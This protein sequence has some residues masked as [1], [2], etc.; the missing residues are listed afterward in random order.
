VA[1][2]GTSAGAVLCGQLLARLK[3]EGLPMPAG[4][5]IFSG[6]G[7]MALTSDIEGYLPPL[8]PRKPLTEVIAPYVGSVDRYDQLMS[9]IYGPLDG[10]PP[11]L[12]MSSTRDVLL[13]QTVRF[14]LALRT[15][16]NKADLFVYEGMPH[17]FWAFAD[18]PETEAAFAEQGR[19]LKSCLSPQLD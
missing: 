3:R 13:S 2:F 12:L 8:L 15:A 18:C 4:V 1:I 16:G 5:G 10:L 17:A 7:D 6:S 11:T 14:H 19:F 9:P